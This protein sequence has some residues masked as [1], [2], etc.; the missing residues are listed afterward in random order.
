MVLGTICGGEWRCKNDNIMPKHKKKKKKLGSHVGIPFKL[1][2]RRHNTMYD[3]IDHAHL[4]NPS[5][6]FGRLACKITIMST[7]PTLRQT[8]ENCFIHLRTL[9]SEVCGHSTTTIIRFTA[10]VGGLLDLTLGNPPTNGHCGNVGVR[11]ALCNQPRTP[12]STRFCWIIYWY[13]TSIHNRSRERLRLLLKHGLRR[14][15]RTL[16]RA[17]NTDDSKVREIK[18]GGSSST[19]TANWACF[20]AAYRQRHRQ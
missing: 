15:H 7:Y 10:V 8:A 6:K 16:R 2:G 9:H 4:R 20:G 5:Y 14:T 19:C 3:Y 18:F 17:P 11:S 1:L 12:K 13:A